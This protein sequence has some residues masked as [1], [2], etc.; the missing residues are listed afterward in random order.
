MELGPSTKN[1][2]NFLI[3]FQYF[4]VVIN[5]TNDQLVKQH[6]SQLAGFVIENDT[7]PSFAIELI[8]AV[9]RAH[10]FCLQTTSTIVELLRCRSTLFRVIRRTLT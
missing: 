3:S 7:K 5:Y 8:R 6:Y 2:Q 10:N 4:C 1:G 9:E